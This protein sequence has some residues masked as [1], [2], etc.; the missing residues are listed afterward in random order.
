MDDKVRKNYMENFRKNELVDLIG[1]LQEE[2]ALLK[3]HT[4]D[5]YYAERNWDELHGGES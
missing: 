4:H 1:K 5:A 2:N 3:E